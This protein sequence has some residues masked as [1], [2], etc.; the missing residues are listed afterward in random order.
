[1]FVAGAGTN[2]TARATAN[3]K[4]NP[5]NG[6]LTVSGTVTCQD[7]NSTSDLV[8]KD[9]IQDIFN[10]IE[11]LNKINPVS[12]NWKK[13]G[14]KSYGVIA[15]QLEKVLPELV[16]T[17]EIDNTKTVSYI[18]IISILIDAVKTLQ[19]EIDDLKNK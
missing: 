7:L 17:N 1:V 19:K 5:N 8:F 3:F 4:I 9:N 10:G 2:Q 14:R 13:D 16:N 18:P 12:F 15:Q 11:I 6:N